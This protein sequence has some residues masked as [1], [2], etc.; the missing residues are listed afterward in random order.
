[1]CS[2]A[3]V[4]Y[5]LK[6]APGN[7]VLVAVVPLLSSKVQLSLGILSPADDVSHPSK[8]AGQGSHASPASASKEGGERPLRRR[9]QGQKESTSGRS[10]KTAAQSVDLAGL[11]SFGTMARVRQLTRVP[12]VPA[13]NLNWQYD[14]QSLQSV[15]TSL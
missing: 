8:R 3:L 1:M 6:Q 4:D 11:H 12:K 2:L 10:S 14:Y 13:P 9:Q 7:D 5:L 15:V